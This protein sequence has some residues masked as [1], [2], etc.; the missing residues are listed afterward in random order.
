MGVFEEFIQVEI[1]SQN[2]FSPVINRGEDGI[3]IITA[4]SDHVH[5]DIEPEREY[6][7][8]CE[9]HLPEKA[10]RHILVYHPRK[11]DEVFKLHVEE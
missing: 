1:I 2:Y 3:P 8:D 5:E 6:C 4:G 7:L 9:R 11:L 10:L